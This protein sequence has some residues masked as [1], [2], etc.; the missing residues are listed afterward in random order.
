MGQVGQRTGEF[1]QSLEPFNMEYA[2]KTCGVPIETLERVAKEIAAADT[3]CVLRAM[4]VT[5]HTNASDGSTAISNLLLATGNY[6]RPAAEPIRCA[7]TTTCRTPV[8]W[9]PCQTAI[10]AIRV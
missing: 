7:G 2:A 3:M 10:R 1:R 6:M 9:E 4:G 8:R 5:Q